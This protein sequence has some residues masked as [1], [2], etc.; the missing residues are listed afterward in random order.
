MGAFIHQ[1]AKTEKDYKIRIA[2]AEA[3][4]EDFSRKYQEATMRA[5]K[6]NSVVTK[7]EAAAPASTAPSSDRADKTAPTVGSAHKRPRS[8]S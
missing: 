5:D 4:H 2:D 8:M 6:Y 3:Q 7:L 1:A